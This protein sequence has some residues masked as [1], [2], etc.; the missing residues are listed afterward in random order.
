MPYLLG[1]TQKISHSTAFVLQTSLSYESVQT[2]LPKDI[3]PYS[4]STSFDAAFGAQDVLLKEAMPLPRNFC[5]S[6]LLIILMT[7]W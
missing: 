5:I 4:Y 2:S 6:I 7:C 3:I 1:A